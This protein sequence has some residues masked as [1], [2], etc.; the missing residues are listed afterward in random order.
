MGVAATGVIG[1]GC[2]TI[3]ALEAGGGAH[4]RSGVH[5]VL[6][7]RSKMRIDTKDMARFHR[8]SPAL[9][10]VMIV[11]SILTSAA[12][13][14]PQRHPAQVADGRSATTR[15]RARL[16]DVDVITP[17]RSRQTTSSAKAEVAAVGLS[18]RA[19]KRRA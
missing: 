16:T 15:C 11:I 12:R 2:E 5:D 17:A 18:G 4:I 7:P 1:V 13:G 19:V 3:L 14:D 6:D 10:V 9:D 8:P